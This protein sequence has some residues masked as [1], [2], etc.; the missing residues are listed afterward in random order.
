MRT[1]TRL[2]A[3]AV[4]TTAIFSGII[5]AG[6]TAANAASGCYNYADVAYGC[7]DRHKAGITDLECDNHEVRVSVEFANGTSTNVFDPDGCGSGFGGKTFDRT[8]V[9]FRICA[10][11]VGCSIWR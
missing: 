7:V 11:G 3:G 9:R 2:L 1:S 6:T 5:V 8:I 4:S 10:D